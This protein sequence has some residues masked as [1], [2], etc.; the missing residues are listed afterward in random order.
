MQR[1]GFAD[2]STN[3]QHRFSAEAGSCEIMAMRPPRTLSRIRG[4]AP[5]NSVASNLALPAIRAFAG[6]KPRAANQVTDLPEPDS[7]TR[8]HGLPGSDLQV[9]AM[10]STRTPSKGR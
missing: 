10:C 1:Q 8:P 5:I 3:A 7:P 9:D 2:L 6:S 4:D